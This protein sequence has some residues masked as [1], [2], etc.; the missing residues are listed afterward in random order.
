MSTID[1]AEIAKF[2]R[3]AGQWHDETGEFSMLHAMNKLRLEFIT[4][5]AAAYGISLQD[6]KILDVGCGG[7]IASIPLAKL[8]A[9]VLGIDMIE[10]NVEAASAYAKAKNIKNAKY[11]NSAIED[12]KSEKFDI[13]IVLEVIEHVLNLEIFIANIKRLL[14]PNGLLFVSTI[15]RTVLSYLQ[16]ILLAEHLIKIV[17][18]GTHE[19]SK[20]VP[21]NKLDLLLKQQGLSILKIEGMAYS[22]F[23]SKWRF[24]SNKLVNYI[25]CA[26]NEQ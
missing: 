6:A 15:N 16:A 3:S 11:I 22:P 20:F 13:I 12:L 7:G 2:R 1:P 21:I 26:S 17:P 18:K 25:L 23:L 24:S 5:Q 9:Q 4:E 8:G 19:W 10:E 14:K